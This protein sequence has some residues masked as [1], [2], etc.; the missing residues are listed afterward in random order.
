PGDLL[1]AGI[2]S[3]PA[4]R[5]AWTFTVYYGG[6]AGSTW[7]SMLRFWRDRTGTSAVELTRCRVLPDRRR[8]QGLRHRPQ[9]PVHSAAGSSEIRAIQRAGAGSADGASTRTRRIRPSLCGTS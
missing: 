5:E 9:Q 6:L 1:L 8:G 7:E 2:W 4:Q 3:D